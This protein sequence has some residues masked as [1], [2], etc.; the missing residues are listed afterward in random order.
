M[1]QPLDAVIDGLD[2][3]ER[4]RVRDRAAELIAEES[5]L[6]DLRRALALTQT[7]LAARLGVGQDS[8]SRLEQRSDLML[9]T[10]SAYVEALGGRLELVARFPDRPPVRLGGLADID[11]ARGEPR[12]SQPDDA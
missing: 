9:S 6:R 7:D 3:E 12:P 4:E 5:S 10:L 8:V 1:A 2:A 11:A